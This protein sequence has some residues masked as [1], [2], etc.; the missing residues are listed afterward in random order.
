MG[1]LSIEEDGISR[2]NAISSVQGTSVLSAMA[3]SQN[4]FQN[5]ITLSED[6]QWE[7]VKHIT[8][9]MGEPAAAP[10]TPKVITEFLAHS[11][12]VKSVVIDSNELTQEV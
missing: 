8:L 9:L 3:K 6:A 1:R 7:C 12:T 2:W 5:L 4:H 11:M 10:P